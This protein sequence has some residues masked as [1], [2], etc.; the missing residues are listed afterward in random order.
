MTTNKVQR[1]AI[2]AIAT[3]FRPAWARYTAVVYAVLE[4][5]FVGAI[6]ALYE[7]RYP[8]IVMQAVAVTFVTFFAMLAAYK[9]GWIKVTQTFRNV[10]VAA[11]L[12]LG[13]FYLLAFALSFFN[14]SMPIITNTGLFGIGFSVFAAGLAAL[15]LVLDFDFIEAGEAEGF[16][17]FM[18]WYGAFTL[19]VTLVW[20]YIELLRLLGKLR[21]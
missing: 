2:I 8:G 16:P 4:G 18:E 20:L 11:T 12:A 17:A 19:T 21:R 13:T 9:F 15:N 10:V 14:V 5:L 1:L 3:A 7:T 6:S